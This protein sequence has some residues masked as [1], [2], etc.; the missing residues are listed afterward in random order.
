MNQAE[1]WTAAGVLLGFQV[2]SFLWRIGQEAGTGAKGDIT[3]LPPAD[4]L[5]LL[6]MSVLAIGVFVAP[7][8]G[9]IS[10]AATRL[11]LGLSVLLF[12]GHSFAL[13]GHY[14]LYNRHTP[15]SFDYFPLQEKIAV[16][17]TLTVV[18]AYIGIAIL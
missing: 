18:G 2:T 10:L 15:R 11:V 3:W 8:M 16:A 5:N 9:A 4:M 17:A 12:V 6:A 14:E 13:A 7:L 1:I